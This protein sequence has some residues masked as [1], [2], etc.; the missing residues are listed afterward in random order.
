MAVTKWGN[1]KLGDPEDKPEFS[2]GSWIAMIFSAAMGASV[3]YWGA[4]EWVYYYNSPPLHLEMKTALAAELGTAYGLFHWTVTPWALYCVPAIAMA[5]MMYVRKSSVMRLSDAGRPIIG[6]HAD[7]YVGKIIDI[8]CV[9][10]LVAG[11]ATTLGLNTPLVEKWFQNF[12]NLPSD[13]CGIP[14][15]IVALII[16]LCTCLIAASVYSGL[17]K[18]IKIL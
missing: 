1:I 6:D 14:G 11:A 16:V 5:Y 9:Y 4:I 17:Y 15:G 7:S 12:F 8:I 10:G 13:L 2:T 18:G 3:L